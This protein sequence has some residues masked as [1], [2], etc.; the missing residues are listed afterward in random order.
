MRCH[1]ESLSTMIHSQSFRTGAI[2][3]VLASCAGD[4][5][6]NCGEP[7]RKGQGVAELEWKAAE[8]TR[9]EGYKVHRGT[10]PGKYTT[11]VDVGNR[12]SCRAE[13]LRNGTTYYFAISSYGTVGESPLSQEVSKTIP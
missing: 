6:I 8:D 2:V 1:T 11:Y 13:N 9:V 4:G 7:S 3:L 5:S 10:V 12:T